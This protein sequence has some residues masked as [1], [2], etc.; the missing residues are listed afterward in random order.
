MNHRFTI[1]GSEALEARIA[2]LCGQCADRI[3]TIIPSSK[4]SCILL[5]GGYGRGEGGVLRNETTDT[6]YNDFEFYVICHDRSPFFI[7]KHQHSLHTLAKDLTRE[8]GI[9]IEFKLLPLRKLQ[10]SPVSMFYY[11]LIARHFLVSGNERDLTT[12]DHQRAAHRIPLSEAT[13]LLMNR[14][15]GLLF[16]E[17]VLNRNPFEANEADFVYRNIAKAKLGMGDVLLAAKGQY[18]W[19]C[20]ERH[21]RLSKVEDE[22]IPSLDAITALHKEGVEFKLRPHQSTLS[23]EVLRT[24]IN[25]IKPLAREVWLW[26]ES[27]RLN[28][29]FSSGQEY[30]MDGSS[31][32][33]E[34]SRLKNR[35]VNLRSFGA[36]GVFSSRYPREKLL[37]AL[38][39]LLWPDKK[40]SAV[41][42][43]EYLQKVLRSKQS[44]LASL[45]DRYTAIWKEY[46]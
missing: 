36:S 20:I 45:I 30:S 6:F 9:E 40:E 10:K 2:E 29:R 5:G 42:V 41:S 32:C 18:H 7:K 4:I 22:S 21:K 31:K 26:L 38:P 37:R 39:L 24:H 43:N 15:S 44:D 28:R 16:S 25:E 14:C 33:P 34:T 1:D 35:L 3:Y 12:C 17:S 11:D 13:R 23:R 27:R 46:N 19:S 8:V